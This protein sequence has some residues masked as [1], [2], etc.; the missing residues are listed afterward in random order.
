MAIATSPPEIP[1][2]SLLSS[3]PAEVL[4]ALSTVGFIHLAL[5]G[6]G[7]AQAD[8][9]RA[10][11][12]SAL[13][14]SVPVEERAGF[15]KD[16]RGN[17]Y[18]GINGSLDER[19]QKA[20]LKESF[21]WGRFSSRAGET[22]TTQRL[23]KNTEQYRQ[24]IIDFDNKCFETSLKVLDILSLAFKLP[25]D[26]FRS[27]HKDAGSNGMAFLNYPALEKPPAGDDIRA[28]S[29]KDWGDV[30]LLFQ[31]KNGQP[32]LQ[33]Y[34]PS[35]DDR[36]K[37][38]IQLIQGENDLKSGTWI[39]APT[40]PNTVLVNVGLTLEGMTDG[41]CKANV[42]RVIFPAETVAVGELP[43]NRK[44]IAYFST[45]NHDIK[46]KVMNPVKP[47]GIIVEKSEQRALT[48]TG[49]PTVG[50]FFMER[51]RLAGVA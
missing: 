37:T 46:Q 50:D 49:A 20:D 48:D 12:L 13:I 31:Q 43:K 1:L 22:A 10:F 26:F 19:T 4:H 27:T 41:L 2:I 18:L 16:E 51:Q 7:L 36:K 11:E 29:H 6:T 5:E 9:D 39:S 47:G 44:S 8:V 17:G 42:H 14:H 3:T 24:E 34:L 45:P 23:P 40:I 15:L 30:T 21:I 38:G 35:E 32:G 25:Q 33:V 28:G